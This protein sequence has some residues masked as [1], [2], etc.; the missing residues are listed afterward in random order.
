MNPTE[1]RPFPGDIIMVCPH[2][3]EDQTNKAIFCYIEDALKIER[4]G[5][6]FY[7]N[8]IVECFPC[9]ML[10]TKESSLHL[11]QDVEWTSMSMITTG[12]TVH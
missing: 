5:F 3:E 7:S 1:L 9:F 2:M 4:E 12:Q 8:W 6:V 10:Q 11:Y